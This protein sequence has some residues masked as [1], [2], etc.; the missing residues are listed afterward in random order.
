MLE[1]RNLR[2]KLRHVVMNAEN[3]KAITKEEAGFVIALVERFR[4]DIED[5]VRKAN[6]LQGEIAQLRKNEQ[7]IINLV[8]NIIAA[9]ERDLARQ[10]TMKKLKEAHEVQEERR[11]DLKAENSGQ[12]DE[13]VKPEE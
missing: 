12:P 4:A 3:K 11:E 6:I 7:V 5:K 1:D 10:E 9:A 2:N 13:E 8:E